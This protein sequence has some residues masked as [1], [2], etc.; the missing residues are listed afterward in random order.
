MHAQRM[1]RADLA[2]ALGCVLRAGPREGAAD[3][4]RVARLLSGER[5]PA[6]ALALA[7]ER[8]TEGA[9]PAGAWVR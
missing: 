5:G 8:L 2:R 4:A 6:L 1:T 7:I 9:V 3:V